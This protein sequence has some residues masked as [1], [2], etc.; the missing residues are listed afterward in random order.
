MKLTGRLLHAAFCRIRPRSARPW[1]R[2]SP[3]AKRMYA[4]LARELNAMLELDTIAI[5]AVRCPHCSAMLDTEHAE[6][7]ACWLS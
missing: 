6:N 2:I 7:H 5:S 4:E 1:R 3:A